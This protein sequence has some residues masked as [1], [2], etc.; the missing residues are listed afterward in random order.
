MRALWLWVAM[1]GV[2]AAQAA[3]MFQ[4]TGGPCSPIV[5]ETRGNVTMTINC[6]GVDPKAQEALHREL[7]LTQGQLRLTQD[8]LARKTQEANN[9]ARQYHELLQRAEN[10]QDPQRTPRAK[11]LVRDGRLKDA[12][13]LLRQSTIT[14]AHYERLQD[15]MRYQEVVNI[16]GRPG[17][18]LGRAGTYVTYM[19]Y[20]PEGPALAAGF[21]DGRMT[22]RSAAML[23]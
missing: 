15:G 19:L 7:G 22:S 5:G 2:S 17:V 6:P 4:Q 3:D 8:Q 18:E 16:L 23:R 14:R 12:E 11:D 1:L 9:W 20:N 21:I 13:A 10:M